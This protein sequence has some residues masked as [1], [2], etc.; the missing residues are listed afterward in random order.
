MLDWAEVCP[1]NSESEK[2][3]ALRTLQSLYV[4]FCIYY[5]WVGSY[6]LVIKM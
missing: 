5:M 4:L 1:T 3:R 2:G 6:I